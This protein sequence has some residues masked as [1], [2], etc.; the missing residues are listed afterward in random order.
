M[1]TRYKRRGFRKIT[2]FD[3][4][5]L[6]CIVAK[7]QISGASPNSFAGIELTFMIIPPFSLDSS[8]TLAPQIVYRPTSSGSS[9]NCIHRLRLS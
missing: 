3:V 4:R 9:L 1:A 5:F 2:C 6:I 7:H 8:S